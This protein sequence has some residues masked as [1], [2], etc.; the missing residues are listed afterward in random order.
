[1]ITPNLE[2]HALSPWL[3]EADDVVLVE[4]DGMEETLPA[5]DLGGGKFQICC[6]PFRAYDIDRG[7]EVVRDDRGYFVSV[8]KKSGDCGF[9]FKTDRDANIIEKIVKVVEQYGCTVEFE[10]SGG[11]I[12]V[13]APEGID[14]EL[15]SGVLATFEDAEYLTYE[16]IRL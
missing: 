3:D 9:R 6:I 14:Q 4:F 2:E 16:T 8:A 10:P 11:L 5:K 7:D 13:N 15:V 12:A 1:M